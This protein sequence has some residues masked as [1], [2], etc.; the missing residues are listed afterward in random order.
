MTDFQSVSSDL[1]TRFNDLI[2][3]DEPHKYY[4][5]GKELVSVT[6]LTHQ[7]KEPFDEEYWSKYKSDQYG[8]EQYKV[9]R[10]WKFI[11][12]K[13]TMK[14]SLIHD[15]AE[16]KLLNKVFRYPKEEIIAEFGFDPI[17]VEYQ[18]TKNHVDNFLRV[19]KNKLIPV[20]T[21]LVMYDEESLLAGMADLI[22]YNVRDKELQIWDWKTNKDFTK[23]C[24]DRYLT[25]MFCTLEECDLEEYSLQLEAYKYILEKNT[26]YKFGKSFLVWVSHNN[27]DFEIIETKN[28][29]FYIE[30]MIQK[31]I[32]ELAA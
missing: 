6:T 1:I 2:Y 4:L 26:P 31:R 28:R 15:Y 7:Y 23:D 14:G 10:A 21:E 5:K 18:K 20:C 24:K 27:E 12:K 13:G 19:A 25:D 30:Q 11:N 9:K 22:F 32:A 8:V 3:Y 17:W 16:N 29:K